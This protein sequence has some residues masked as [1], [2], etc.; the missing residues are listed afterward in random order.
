MI[1]GGKLAGIGYPMNAKQEF[2]C[3]SQQ[4]AIYAS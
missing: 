2:G 1:M 4:V 3:M